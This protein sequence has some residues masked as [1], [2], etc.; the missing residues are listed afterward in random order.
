MI[1]RIV[2]GL[3]ILV[4]PS[5]AAAQNANWYAGGALAHVDTRFE[6]DYNVLAT[7]EDVKFL[8]EADGLQ[9]EATVGRRHRLHDRFSLGY[10]G[11]FSFN[12]V[13]WTLS[14]PSEPAEFTYALPRTIVVAVVPEVTVHRVISVFGEIGTGAGFVHQTKSSSPRSSYDYEA[15]R[16]VF[17]IGGGARVK[18]ASKAAIVVSYRHVAYSGYEFDT[19]NPAGVRIEH[20]KDAPCASGV[21]FGL[22]FDF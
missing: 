20:V 4:A 13:E 2:A 12:N 1:S 21:S 9:V 10:Q 17:A 18:V 8:N 19:F 22:A 15:W 3:L 14:L 7:G 11:T 5:I 6:P 16:P